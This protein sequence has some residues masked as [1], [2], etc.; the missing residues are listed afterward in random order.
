V[1]GLGWPERT[2]RTPAT[3]F[4]LTANYDVGESLELPAASGLVP[5][6]EYVHLG[7]FAGE[8]GLF[9]YELEDELEIMIEY[10]T[11]LFEEPTMLRLREHLA[12]LLE[13]A[14]AN[15]E[16]PLSALLA[17][18]DSLVGGERR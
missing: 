17:G 18:I 3:Q 4:H 6:F 10:R 7:R 2:L 15:P 16:R 12:T 13:R 1:A 8:L 9:T 11:D 14:T 5:R